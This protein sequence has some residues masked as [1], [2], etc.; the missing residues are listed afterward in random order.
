LAATNEPGTDPVYQPRLRVSTG[1]AFTTY[2]V[3]TGSSSGA[4]GRVLSD[5]TDAGGARIVTYESV[6]GIFTVT[7]TITG[8]SS[9]RTTTVSIIYGQLGQ[10]DVELR[11]Y[12]EIRIFKEKTGTD[13]SFTP[14][15]DDLNKWGSSN[16]NTESATSAR[17]FLSHDV[18]PV[19]ITKLTTISSG[20]NA[21][22]TTIPVAALDNFP[23][24]GTIKIGAEEITYTGKSAATGAGNLTGGTREVNSTTAASHSS[25]AS[26]ILVRMALR[27]E[28]TSGYRLQDWDTD[29][30]G[31]SLTIGD[32]V[33]NIN[34]KNNISPPTE[35]T[36]YKT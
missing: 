22:V 16:A 9:G 3:I 17:T 1:T 25:G 6:S 28:K 10:R 30:F 2:E 32:I 11:H 24:S 23:T 21:S 8:S 12:L 7:E 18:Y 35:I 14:N 15:Y 4:T 33:N 27:Q 13:Y 31:T 26:V 5:D 34:Y 19:Y 29:Q 36:M 20:I